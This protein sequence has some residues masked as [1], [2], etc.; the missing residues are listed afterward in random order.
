LLGRIEFVV[1]IWRKEPLERISTHG[2]QEGLTEV[3]RKVL[4]GRKGGRVHR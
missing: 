3:G 4:E 2:A 1:G